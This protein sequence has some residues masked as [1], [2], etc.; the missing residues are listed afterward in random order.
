MYLTF[1]N[2]TDAEI[3]K[4][5]MWYNYIMETANNTD[6]LVGD[7]AVH[8]FLSELETMTESQVCALCIYGKIHGVVQYDSGL[9]TGYC[10]YSIAN[11]DPNLYIIAKPSESIMAGVVN[12]T[13][14][15]DNPL[16]WPDILHN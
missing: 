6:K 12:Y 15:E 16:W 10:D 14:E 4:N 13:E 1:T 2:Q 5:K 3:A 9:T 8:Y 7:G 11:N